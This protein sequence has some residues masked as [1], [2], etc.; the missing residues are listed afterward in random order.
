MKGKERILTYL[1][2]IKLAQP[3]KTEINIMIDITSY[4]NSICNSAT[5][6]FQNN[7][8]RISLIWVIKYNETNLLHFY[9]TIFINHRRL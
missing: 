6:V 8:V 2:I 4:L 3:E 9:F 1:H 7:I 5:I